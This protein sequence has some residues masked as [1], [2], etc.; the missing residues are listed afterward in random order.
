MVNESSLSRGEFGRVAPRV[1]RALEVLE[2]GT[3]RRV[4][5]HDVGRDQRQAGTNQTRVAAR[6]EQRRA[7]AQ[8]RESIAMR[9][10]NARDEP[11]EP[12]P[13]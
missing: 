8:V 11:M 9:F 1:H 2:R 12:E 6:G 4:T 10:V 3:Q 7:Q 13:A 5:Q